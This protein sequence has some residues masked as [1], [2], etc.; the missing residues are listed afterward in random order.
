M[1]ATVYLV[2]LFDA[3]GLALVVIAELAFA[4]GRARRR[5]AIDVTPLLPMARAR[6]RR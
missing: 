3:L 4:L 6:R 2:V 1:I 5:E